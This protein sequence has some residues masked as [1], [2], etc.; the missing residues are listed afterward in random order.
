MAFLLAVLA[1]MR[2]EPLL[3]TV[4]GTVTGLFAVHA[5]DGRLIGLVFN[6]LLRA[7]LEK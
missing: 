4:T 5:L 7:A 2:I 6:S 3:G 1:S